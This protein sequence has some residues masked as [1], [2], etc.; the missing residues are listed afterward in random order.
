MSMLSSQQRKQALEIIARAASPE[1]RRSAVSGGACFAPLPQ[2]DPAL[3]Q[4]RT[5]AWIEAVAAG[6]RARFNLLLDARGIS[7]DEFTR[8]LYEVSVKPGAP[9]PAWGQTLLEMLEDFPGTENSLDSTV[10]NGEAHGPKSPMHETLRPFLGM[11]ERF[12]KRKARSVSLTMSTRAETQILLTLA[13]RLFSA[14]FGV[15]ENEM[16]NLSAAA[17]MLQLFGA[18]RKQELGSSLDAWLN[19]FMHYPVLARVIAV[20]YGNWRDHMSELIDRLI[21][22]REL[23]RLNIFSGELQL[24]LTN[25]WGD[26]GDIHEDGRSVALL[27]IEHGKRIAYKPKDLRIAEAFMRLVHFLNESGLQLPLHFRKIL[28]RTG[29]TWEQYIEHYPCEDTAGVSRFYRRMGMMIR[30]LQLLGARDFWLDNLIASG[31]YP[32]FIDYEMVLQQRTE[33]SSSLL[34]AEKM[35]LER[36]EESV[37]Y[38]GIVSYC[39]PIDLGVKAEDMGA[40]T[41]VR[42]LGSPFKLSKAT[43]SKNGI[44]LKLTP[45]GYVSWEKRDYTPVTGGQPAKAVEYLEEVIA[46]YREMHS[47][48]IANKTTLLSVSGPVYALAAL[49]IRYIHRDTWSCMKI[50]KASVNPSLLVDGVKREIYLEGLFKTAFNGQTIKP[51][52]LRIV[53]GE[54]DFFRELDIP[55]FR[56]LSLKNSVLGK[57]ESEIENYFTGTALER[58]LQR[59]AE[60][61]GFALE[62]HIDIIRSTLSS[63][64]HEAPRVSTAIKSER[65]LSR[66]REHDGGLDTACGIGDFILKQAVKSPEKDVAWIGLVY[67]PHMDFN[68]VEV[69][70]PDILSGTCGLAILFADLYAVTGFKRFKEGAQKALD[71]TLR[72]ILSAPALF[73][74]VQLNSFANKRPLF[75]GAFYGLGGQ[76][77]A[78]RRCARA[79]DA[80]G[81]SQQASEYVKMLPI[82]RLCQQ[83][84]SD[85]ISGAS[86]LMAALL[87]G[88]ADDET[89]AEQILVI[90]QELLANKRERKSLVKPLY[91]PGGC[92][93]NGLPDLEGGVAMSC[94]RLIMMDDKR[95]SARTT[96]EIDELIQEQER[97]VKARNPTVGRLLS[98]LTI[99]QDRQTGLSEMLGEI[100]EYVKTDPA[101]MCSRQL[102]DAFDLVTSAY[103]ASND[104]QFRRRAAEFAGSLTGRYK[105][106]GSWLPD[107]ISADRHNLSVITGIGAIAHGLLRLHK[108]DRIRSIRQLH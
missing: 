100:K 24:H 6:D 52:L 23:L 69:L 108:P 61:E 16:T 1:E 27:E 73:R 67:H 43:A 36:I 84:S 62:E 102:I 7:Q 30:L 10:E 34:P 107:Q 81:L 98:R 22:D 9:L 78:L 47:C 31:E 8:G 64:P 41:P 63:G 105:S 18:E 37:V 40:L 60:L 59:V 89:C 88:M 71:S 13:R 79:I 80:P 20:V 46:G 29:Y 28:A 70:R 49:P 95:L 51:N 57:H 15:L 45:G 12:V 68:S 26:T 55:L 91:P 25:F 17:G 99:S 21:N 104:E 5:S 11:G 103:Q 97:I 77:Y 14:C 53:Q 66:H 35:A 87:P 2:Q 72:T 3:I 38:S 19:R 42:Q 44:D 65:K 58:T 92:F 48:L 56:S 75:I 74:E 76:V 93:L 83:V 54:I 85:L 4:A 96:A 50:I 39:A 33:E 82:A 101:Q 86:G 106:T 94:S 90:A 32:V